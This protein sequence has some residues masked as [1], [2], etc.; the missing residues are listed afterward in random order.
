MSTRDS[1]SRTKL[2]ANGIHS[3]A[4]LWLRRVPSFGRRYGD[5]RPPKRVLHHPLVWRREQPSFRLGSYSLSRI[6]PLIQVSFLSPCISWWCPH[7][8]ND[9]SCC[10]F[11]PLSAIAVSY[12]LTLFSTPPLFGL[13]IHYH[14]HLPTFA[15]DVTLPVSTVSITI[16]SLIRPRNTLRHR[17][18][19]FSHIIDTHT[20]LLPTVIHLLFSTLFVSHKNAPLPVYLRPLNH[21][22]L[23]VPSPR[24]SSLILGSLC[25][26]LSFPYPIYLHDAVFVGLP[27]LGGIVY[28]KTLNF[29]Y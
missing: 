8:L 26:S 21:Q 9:H 20:M 5:A 13:S 1:F 22:V 18:A 4:S 23:S 11:D 19:N 10:D 24:S 17:L 27:P 28:A 12:I 6:C 29:V 15:V 14:Y 16:G 7:Q 3:V 2:C 25:M